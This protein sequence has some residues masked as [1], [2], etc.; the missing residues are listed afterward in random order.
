MSSYFT[1]RHSRS[2]NTLPDGKGRWIEALEEALAR[3]GTPE[4]FNTD[5]GSQFTDDDFTAPLLAK[6]VRVSMG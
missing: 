1:L 4:I 3:Y 6:G 2:T 5:Q